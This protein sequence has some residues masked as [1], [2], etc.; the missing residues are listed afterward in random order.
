MDSRITLNG[1]D[2]AIS[3]LNYRHKN[4]L[5][6]RLLGAVRQAYTDDDTLKNLKAI[7]PDELV[8]L[9][10]DT[11]NAPS[12]VQNKRKNLSSIKSTVN[13]DLKKLF[14]AG[15]NPEGVSIGPANIFEMSSD[16]KDALLKSF[17]DTGIADGPID[18]GQITDILNI[19]EEALPD[20]ESI[21]AG[22]GIEGIDKLD[23]IKALIQDMAEK[24]G[25]VVDINERSEAE[26]MD[27]I[28]EEIDEDGLLDAEDVDAVSEEA[29]ET[30]EE[31]DAD[32]LTDS[33]ETDEILEE[34]DEEERLDAENADAVS[35]EA[36][37]DERAEAE[38]AN[39][40]LEEIDEDEHTDIEKARVLSES[41]NE[42]LAAM[43]KFYNQYILVS[44][45]DYIVGSVRP[46]QD[47]KSE[48]TVRLA[49]FY[50]GKFP[51]TN[52]LF[53]V[54]V[55]KTGYLTTAEK[56]GHGTVYGGRTQKTVDIHTGEEKLIWNATLTNKTVE[57]ACWYQPSGPG[58][59]LHKKRN[60]PVTQ[61]SLE[62][63]MAFAA[64]AGKRLPTEDEWEA[65]SRTA[66]GHLFP[67]GEQWQTEAC[68]IEASHIGDTTPV[69]RYAEF[70]NDFGIND[71]IGNVLEWTM[72]R[73][74]AAEM[75][76]ASAYY[77]AKGGSWISEN[78]VSLSRRFQ[79][80][81][82]SHSNILGFRCV[83]F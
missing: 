44:E 47:E 29:D 37:A 5:K 57:G 7:D 51:V 14:D 63:A 15:K 40:I 74:E 13:A 20:S 21:E 62:D 32:E 45:G 4:A 12:V 54:F 61:V 1:I 64:W 59:V 76:G 31:V 19:I 16:A 48:I 9:L 80:E 27:E 30:L 49:P 23:V 38:E 70:E 43:D 55:E 73:V 41:F 33:E 11:G 78:D 42:S 35:E 81:P 83:A 58:S 46:V 24:V 71:T 72:D 82:E 77:I 10:W 69:D 34:I 17:I 75:K 65:A 53:E 60:H 39:E 3:D 36:D 50:L 18:F 26:E 22:K 79:L 66:Q 2:Q 28:L 25:L 6:C 52:A 56:K 68:N 67:W 8:R